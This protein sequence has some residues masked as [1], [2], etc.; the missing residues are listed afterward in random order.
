[1]M[2]QQTSKRALITG[3]TGFAGSRLAHRLYQEGWDV[4]AI[5]RP[6]SNTD[7]LKDMVPDIK[8]HPHDGTTH[9]MI[10]IIKEAKPDVVFHLASS[11]ISH[12]EAEDIEALIRSNVLFG[13]QLAEAMASNGIRRLVNT[14]TSWQ[15]FQNESYNPVSLYAATK[16]AF[17]DIL[18]F[19]V[20]TAAL[21]VITLKLFDTYG[22][23]DTRRKFLPLLL[24]T[25]ENG[26]T[27]AMSA[28]EQLIDLVHIDDVTSAFSLAAGR[29]LNGE[30]AKY[31]EYA[32]SSGHPIP[33]NSLV[34]VF[35]KVTGRELPIEWGKR[36][37]RPREVMVPWNKGSKLPGWEPKIL[38]EEGLRTLIASEEKK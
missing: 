14:G 1:M 18:A 21:Q 8:V 25:A 12:H 26:Q 35:E 36:P 32:V 31:E 37:Y 3:A 23:H 13:T 7:S 5:I 28:G 19:Y 10:T 38:L 9:H 34:K 15:H 17:E 20:E 11:V 4:N 30:A 16:Q 2:H 22:P 6:H 24:K 33:L 27:L 29:L